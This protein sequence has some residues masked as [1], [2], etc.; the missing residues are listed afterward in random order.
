MTSKIEG[1]LSALG[2]GREGFEC[3]SAEREVWVRSYMYIDMMTIASQ[4]RENG[5]FGFVMF[6]FPPKERE[7]SKSHLLF[8]LL[9]RSFTIDGSRLSHLTYE[10]VFFLLF[11]W[12]S[13][14]LLL[15]WQPQ[16][17]KKKARKCYVERL[18]QLF[19][20]QFVCDFVSCARPDDFAECFFR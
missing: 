10:I 3:C 11:L 19:S 12:N 14:L 13:T 8:V 5:G 4:Q 16:S 15:R 18:Q 20:V 17:M 1:V 7:K 9:V 6:S 2:Y